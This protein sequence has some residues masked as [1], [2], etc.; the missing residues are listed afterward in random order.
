MSTVVGPNVAE[1]EAEELLRDYRLTVKMRL[2]KAEP[3]LLDMNVRRPIALWRIC[4]LL[5]GVIGWGWHLHRNVEFR[6]KNERRSCRRCTIRL[7]TDMRLS[8]EAAN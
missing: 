6:I 8:S 4:L 2:Y 5:C 3:G 1:A 7:Q